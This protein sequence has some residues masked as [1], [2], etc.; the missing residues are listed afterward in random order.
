MAQEPCMPGIRTRQGR[1]SQVV[2]LSSCL[3][4]CRSLHQVLPSAITRS[5]CMVKRRLKGRCQL[6]L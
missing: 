4:R 6:Q 1:R 5:V 3:E 2:S